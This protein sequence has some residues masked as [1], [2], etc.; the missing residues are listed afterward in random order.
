M[1]RL[2]LITVLYHSD[3]VLEEFIAGISLQDYRNYKLYLV[4]NTCNSES[5][6]YLLELLHKYPVAD[7]EHIDSKGNIGVAAGNNLGLHH[8][9]EDECETYLF[10]NNDI[11]ITQKFLLSKIADLAVIHKIVTPKIFY[12]DS[13]LIW[14]AGGFIDQK[15]ALG[16]HYGMK[17]SDGPLF[18]QSKYVTYAPTCFLA[19]H[20]SVVHMI[21]EMDERY[22]AYYDDTDFVYRAIKKGIHVWYESSLYIYHKVSSSSGGDN[23]LFYIYYGNRNKL[24]FIRKHFKGFHKYYLLAYYFFVRF[25]FYFLRYNPEQQKQLLKA[26]R[27]G[28]SIRL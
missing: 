7:Y 10:L 9:Q 26:T 20:K 3:K 15:K 2:A 18:N 13:K 19:V 24:I 16:V 23:S 21:G 4:D 8:A 27:D 22:F 11:V 14:M 12:Y 17:Q 25:F 1:P 28:W 5:T 6:R